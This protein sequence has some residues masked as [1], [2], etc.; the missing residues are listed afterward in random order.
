MA[1]RH[2]HQDLDRQLD[3]FTAPRPKHDTANPIRTDGPETLARTLP[4]DGTRIGTQGDSAPDASGSGGEDQGRN[5]DAAHRTDEAGGNRATGQR[6]GL[7][8]GAGEIHPA[9][10]GELNR[11]G[12]SARRLLPAVRNE[13]N[14]RISD[15]DRIG[16]GP[17]RQKY[18]Q[19]IAAIRTLRTMEAEGRPATPDEKAV[20]VRYV[21][22]GAM[23]Q[24]FDPRNYEWREARAEVE[25]MLTPEELE[26]ARASTLN[27]HYTSPTVVRA[28]YSAL[29]RFGFEHGR[30]LEPSCGIGHFIGL[31]PETMHCH[32]TVT[33][34]EIDPLTARIAKA[35]YPDADIRAQGFENAQL[36]DGFYDVAI[37]NVPFG[38]YPVHDRRLIAYRFPIHDYFFA[39][40]LDKVR[41]GGLVMFITSRGTMDKV[42]S[43]LREYLAPNT[44]FLGAIRLP[45]TAFKQNA[46]TEVTTDIVMLRKLHPGETPRGAAWRE[47]RDF[48]NHDFIKIPINEY[49]VERPHLMLGHLQLTGRMYRDN[50][51]TLEGDGRVLGDALA[52]AIPALPAGI[53]RAQRVELTEPTTEQTIP[54]PDFIKPNAYC[55]HDGIVCIRE[56]NVLRRLSDLPSDT[57]SRIRRLIQVRDAVRLC[58]RSQMDASSEEQV[59]EA[60]RQLNYAY[61]NFVARFGPVN[62]RANQRAFDGDPDLPLLLSLEHYND[63]TKRAIKA[64]I[65]HERT[66]HHRQPIESVGS[67]KEALLVSLNERGRVDLDHMAG[68]LNKPT[69][70]FLPELKGI[71]FLNPQT[72]EL[73][74]DDQY[75]SGYVRKKL[76]VAEAAA[77]TD[78]RFAEN[79]EALKS[80]QP[81]DLSATEIDVRL[82]ACWLPSEDV[83]QFTHELLNI[84]AGVE[85]GHVHALGTWHLNGDWEARGATGNTTDWGTDRYTA[86]ELI[87]DALNLKTPTV[88]DLNE[89]RKPVVNAQAT[90][91]AREKQERIKERFKEWI[92]SD[93]SR[94]ERLCRLYNDTFNHTRLRTFNG[95]HL[96]LP[97]ASE[98]IQLH[99]HQKAGVWRILQTP[100]TLLAHVVGAGKTYTMVAAAMELKRLGFARKPVFAVPNH[101]LGQFSAELLTLYPGA[102]ILVA[103]KLDFESQ[104]RKKLFSR[105]ATGNWDAVIVTHSG[106]E[107]I[108]LARETQERFFEEQLHE[109]EMI[110][111]QLADVIQSPS[112]EGD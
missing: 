51:P 30:I 87:E 42:N 94:R 81:E 33:G 21:G 112:R 54:A 84:S 57:R 19:N 53:Y 98:A 93:D 35:L 71:M 11:S 64:T 61:D 69:E 95:D 80:V 18:R 101:M 111:R 34:I 4:E 99:G 10:A 38:D 15:A 110:R 49:F 12:R 106:F 73:E 22:W 59:V 72:N 60:R 82:G 102:N 75:L 26:S 58:L 44:E 91:A 3:L 66:I 62:L 16:E 108:P 70:E 86:L 50:E 28:M 78:P 31:M 97:G 109:L 105:I 85:I 55:V 25:Q 29:E 45:N 6:P 48:T 89:E 41:A 74:T 88:Y 23:P 104:N 52:E 96:T 68:L 17:P 27:A 9:P 7:G 37:S 65:F 47:L 79:V 14:H 63:E 36:A 67:P 76:T 5:G 1:V 40:A 100:N 8:D 103:G 43:T 83:K 46:G 24:V 107:R 92:W 90:E 2:N 39:K 13:N 77:V 56:E 32:S 20:L